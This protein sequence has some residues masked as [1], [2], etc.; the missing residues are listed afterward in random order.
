MAINDDTK[1]AHEIADEAQRLRQDLRWNVK[2]GE[3]DR[4]QAIEA[5]LEKIRLAM[6]PIRSA[7]GLAAWGK[8]TK[9]AEAKLRDASARLQYERRQL[10]KMQR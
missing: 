1:K 3:A 7:M 8:V 2:P 5:C 10:K 4:E 9:A 6:V